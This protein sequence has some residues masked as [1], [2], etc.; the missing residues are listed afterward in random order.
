MAAATAPGTQLRDQPLTLLS[1]GDAVLRYPHPMTEEDFDWLLE[2][3]RRLKKKLV[4]QPPAPSAEQ[5]DQ[6]Q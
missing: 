4:A 5:G 6:A 3:L 1:A 2:T